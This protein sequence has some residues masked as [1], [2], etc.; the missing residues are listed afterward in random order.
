MTYRNIFVSY[1]F[2]MGANV[3]F[4]YMV[5]NR[6]PSIKN[7]IG[8]IKDRLFVKALTVLEIHECTDNEFN[9]VTFFN[10]D[11]GLKEVEYNKQL[12]DSEDINDLYIYLHDTYGYCNIIS[13]KGMYMT[14]LSKNFYRSE[15]KCKCGQCDQDMVD[16]ELITVLQ[17][18]RDYFLRSVKINSGNRCEAHNTKIGGS[19]KSQH[20][21]SKA[22]DIEVDYIKPDVVADYLEQKYQDK[23]G[24]GR[25]GNFTH[26]DVRDNKTRW[27]MR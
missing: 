2:T 3:Q 23:Y 10:K 11:I 25:Y 16:S 17:D 9:R 6:I 27:D 1:M 5:F 7:L 13:F 22:S 18:L 24:I 26:I 21:Y 8:F 19:K 20:L 14:Q 4:G 12:S 15:F